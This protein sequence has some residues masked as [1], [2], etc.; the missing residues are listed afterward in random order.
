MCTTQ[1]IQILML[2]AVL[3]VC[4]A[5]CMNGICGMHVVHIYMYLFTCACICLEGVCIRGYMY[6]QATYLLV[7]VH[8]STSVG[9]P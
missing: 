8:I 5:V 6:T 9:G 4:S 7:L 3:D 2:L 1:E